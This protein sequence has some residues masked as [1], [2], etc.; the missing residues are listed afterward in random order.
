[1]DINE[2]KAGVAKIISNKVDFRAQ[3]ITGDKRDIT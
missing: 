1:M 3:R 2:K